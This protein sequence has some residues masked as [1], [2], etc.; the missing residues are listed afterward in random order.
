MKG[1]AKAGRSNNGTSAFAKASQGTSAGIAGASKTELSVSTQGEGSRAM[2][3]LQGAGVA[4]G[5][6][7]AMVHT[8]RIESSTSTQQSLRRKLSTSTA[9]TAIGIAPNSLALVSRQ[10][11]HLAS[12]VTPSV[13][14]LDN[15]LIASRGDASARITLAGEAEAVAASRTGSARIAKNKNDFIIES[16]GTGQAGR[17][18]NT[19]WALDGG[20]MAMAHLPSAETG[21]IFCPCSMRQDGVMCDCP[22]H[23]GTVVN[24]SQGPQ[25]VYQSQ[26]ARSYHQPSQAPYGDY[27]S[28]YQ[29]PFQQAPY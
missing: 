19:M 12:R 18:G 5:T 29:S 8:N 16:H 10:S 25:P 23:G 28:G 3:S 24:H 1:E 26:Y 22:C 21:G 4:A 13:Q 2:A 6:S 7:S 20:N 9:L 17:T 14:R 11:S 27:S 15:A